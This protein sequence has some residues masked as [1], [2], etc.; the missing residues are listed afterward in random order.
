MPTIANVGAMEAY[1]SY[2]LQWLGPIVFP[3]SF[4]IPTIAYVMHSFYRTGIKTAAD[5]VS[6]GIILCEAMFA[7]F[8]WC[9]CIANYHNRDMSGGSDACYF[10]AIYATIYL[11]S[12]VLLVALAAIISMAPLQRLSAS[13]ATAA[14]WILGIFF[15]LLPQMGAGQYRFPKDFCMCDLEDPVYAALWL[16]LWAVTAGLLLLSIAQ[17]YYMVQS[18]GSVEL[19][20]VS[21]DA[22]T[23]R[24]GTLL[25]F[26]AFFTTPTII[27]CIYLADQAQPDTIYGALA[28]I[29]HTQQ[30]ANPLLYGL[31]WRPSL[32]STG[33]I[34]EPT[35]PI[36]PSPTTE[37]S[38]MSSLGHV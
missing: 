18:G 25:A 28:I 20:W 37:P 2:D 34:Q 26:L 38:D 3:L 24:I 16:V 11:F 32:N 29:L 33:C 7:I 14:C 31:L 8:C 36:K 10:Q 5:A 21:L 15:A 27:V 35:T 22:G 9:Q 30:I 12:S 6:F 13:I 4:S 1:T 19:G 17:H 23:V